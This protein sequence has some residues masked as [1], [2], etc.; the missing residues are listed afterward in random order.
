MTTECTFVG[1]LNLI[2]YSQLVIV[3][4]QTPLG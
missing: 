1:E 4:K 2:M 3:T